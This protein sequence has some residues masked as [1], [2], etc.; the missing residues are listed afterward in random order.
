M[1]YRIKKISAEKYFRS[2][3]RCACGKLITDAV[4]V[5]LQDI[6]KFISECLVVNDVIERWFDSLGHGADEENDS[7][8]VSAIQRI[9]ALNRNHFVISRIFILCKMQQ[10]LGSFVDVPGCLQDGTRCVERDHRAREIVNEILRLMQNFNVMLLALL[11]RPGGFGIFC[12][13]LVRIFPNLPISQ[14]FQARK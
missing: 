7:S 10:N 8:V 1:P 2:Q 11:R 9:V 6:N 14:R 12:T 5:N 4:T 13:E 3:N